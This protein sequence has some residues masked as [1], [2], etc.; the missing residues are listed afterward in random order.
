MLSSNKSVISSYTAQ[1]SYKATYR[2]LLCRNLPMRVYFAFYFISLFLI[3]V[4]L[5]IVKY[6]R[7]GRIRKGG[8]FIDIIKREWHIS[9][10]SFGKNAPNIKLVYIFGRVFVLLVS[11]QVGSHISNRSLALLKMKL[12]PILVIGLAFFC[13]AFCWEN[14][15]VDQIT[16]DDNLIFSHSV[17]NID[18]NH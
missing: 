2:S 12:L 5:P 18:P 9:I 3:C 11:I 13:S 15:D 7:L 1:N 17:S 10:S 14:S 4:S 16:A 8:M 6:V